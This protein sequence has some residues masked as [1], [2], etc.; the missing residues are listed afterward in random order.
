M[1]SKSC[2][3]M[4]LF[5]SLQALFENGNRRHLNQ[6]F[7]DFSG[8]SILVAD[9]DT[10][11]RLV[12]KAYLERFGASVVEAEHGQAVLERLDEEPVI[13]AIV[14][15]MNMP[16]MGGL[17]T[18]AAIRARTDA[19]ASVPIIALTSQSDIG[20]V[21]ACMSVGMNEVMVKPVQGGSLYA[22]LTR[23]LRNSVVVAVVAA[24]SGNGAGAA[25]EL[26]RLPTLGSTARKTQSSRTISSTAN[27]LR[28]LARS[29]SS[30]RRF[31]AVS[32][33]FA[34]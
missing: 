8:K 4:E 29:A 10:Y 12:A 28:E 19:H 32:S 14:V 33:R 3:V 22:C 15:D 9:D 16:G 21:Q 2:S 30:T 11:N 5:T 25:V 7:D 31:Q 26:R 18:A 27:H 34:R 6:R 1:I 20:S 13:D 23:Q 24:K 17:E